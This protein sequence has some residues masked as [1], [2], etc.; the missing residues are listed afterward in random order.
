MQEPAAAAG[1]DPIQVPLPVPAPP[2]ESIGQDN[3]QEDPSLDTNGKLELQN[4][5]VKFGPLK[6]AGMLSNYDVCKE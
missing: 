1:L 3:D 5:K 4:Y 6:L 2:Q